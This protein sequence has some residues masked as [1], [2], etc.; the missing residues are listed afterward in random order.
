MVIHGNG[1]ADSSPRFH[2]AVTK[3]CPSLWSLPEIRRRR[4]WRSHI[5]VGICDEGC[6]L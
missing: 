5:A 4:E 6:Q 3:H 2:R 1:G